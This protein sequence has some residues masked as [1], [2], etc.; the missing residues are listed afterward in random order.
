[1]PVAA[2]SPSATGGASGNANVDAKSAWL[3]PEGWGATL[4]GVTKQTVLFSATFYTLMRL[5][6]EDVRPRQA[7]TTGLLLGAMAVYSR[8]RGTMFASKPMLA[9]GAL[10]L[11]AMAIAAVTSVVAGEPI[12]EALTW[13]G[14][15]GVLG[16]AMLWMGFNARRGERD[17]D[18]GI[19]GERVAP[20]LVSRDELR[21]RVQRLEDAQRPAMKRVTRWFGVGLGTVFGA[22]AF[23]YER[24]FG[25]APPEW[26]WAAAFFGFWGALGLS[27]RLSARQQRELAERRGLICT[28]CDK[29][30]FSIFG[31]TRLMKNL[32]EAGRC[33]QCGARI[34]TEEVP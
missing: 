31:N 16:G 21:A 8:R 28:A 26:A 6:G 17:L 12:A 29:A 22:I 19:H 7:I 24:V 30:Y 34:V 25:A 4:F 2:A 15:G 32:A 13:L 23:P 33:P 14:L 11:G 3:A 27:M 9:M 10:T 5:I 1:M 18:T 20:V